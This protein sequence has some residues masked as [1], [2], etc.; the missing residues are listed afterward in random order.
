M[1]SLCYEKGEYMLKRFSVTNF[2]N[3]EEKTTFHFDEVKDYGFNKDLIKE[4]D[5]HNKI[6]N[7]ALV[8]GENGAGKSNLGFAIMEINNHLTNKFKSPFHYFNITNANSYSPWAVFEYVFSDASGKEIVYEYS[9]NDSLN[10]GFEK[11]TY[12]G[13][14][15][16]HYDYEKKDL[17]KTI[18]EAKN[19][20]INYL[21]D[22]MSGINYIGRTVPLPA[23]HPIKFITEFADGMLW[24]R[25]VRNNEFMGVEGNPENLNSYLG[26]PSRIAE[27][28]K[29]LK[30]CGLDYDLGTYYDISGKNLLISAKYK[31]RDLNFFSIASAG[32]A[33]LSLLYYWLTKA[34]NRTKFLFID[35]F[36]A[37]YHYDLAEKILNLINGRSE[38]Q[39]V[40]TTH[41]T[42]LMNNSFMRPDTYFQIENN[43]IVSLADS[44]NK[45]IREGNN[46]ERMYR[47]NEFNRK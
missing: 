43:K 4:D 22:N 35:E 47:A 27:F 19:L 46:L 3:F 32:T 36:D 2:K 21:A 25:S 33:S 10:F 40:L 13:E 31:N 15:I 1:L 7:K 30:E 17:K 5:N 26:D 20:I 16:Y 9:K 18:K 39:S 28:N 23:S 37:F 24:F 45:V 14:L 8:Y 41:N 34:E 29:F 12:D 6:I 42:Y 11:V 44:T 38:F